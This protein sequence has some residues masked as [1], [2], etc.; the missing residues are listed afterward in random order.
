M[1]KLKTVKNGELKD[2]QFEEEV[3]VE[4]PNVKRGPGRPRKNPVNG[5]PGGGNPGGGNPG[6]KGKVAVTLSDLMS[7]GSN[8]ND[9]AGDLKVFDDEICKLCAL[10]DID[11]IIHHGNIVGRVF[12]D[13]S[14][15][16]QGFAVLYDDTKAVYLNDASTTAPYI[17]EVRNTFTNNGV[18]TNKHIRQFIIVKPGQYPYVQAIAAQI[19]DSLQRRHVGAGLTFNGYIPENLS[20]TLDSGT[21]LAQCME[22]SAPNV[23]PRADLGFVINEVK[24]TTTVFDSRPVEVIKPLVA[25]T[26]YVHMFKVPGPNPYDTTP[27]FKPMFVITCISTPVPVFGTLPLALAYA[28]DIMISNHGWKAQFDPAKSKHVNI[29]GL[30]PPGKNGKRPEIKDIRE[31]NAFIASHIYK[32][33]NG[34]P[35]VGLAMEIAASLPEIEGYDYLQC[36]S[37]YNFA[38]ECVNF[39]EHNISPN[40]LVQ[41][42]C[43]D[44]ILG[45]AS[46]QN[47]IRDSRELDYLKL[48]NSSTSPNLE[49]LLLPLGG[50]DYI[51]TQIAILGG[52]IVECDLTRHL[53]FTVPFLNSIMEA[54]V[55]AL[56]NRHAKWVLSDPTITPQDANVVHLGGNSQGM[57]LTKRLY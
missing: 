11:S 8:R 43:Y 20:V 32:A 46:I 56:R 19:I 9:I 14:N 50:H 48:V 3:H 33:P 10:K 24:E 34:L 41:S 22:W 25:V 4:Q 51:N 26:G 30:L 35:E 18:L 16:N 21:A 52:G 28:A 39:F 40:V 1:A 36:G 37:E 6:G 49:T 38:A 55:R 27:L 47:T 44:L 23:A 45:Q 5:N 57:D 2:I 17:V 54:A 12:F 7:V 29:G 53:E 15:P 31:L 13:K 42:N